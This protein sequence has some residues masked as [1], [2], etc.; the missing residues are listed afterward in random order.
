MYQAETDRLIEQVLDGD[1]E[2]YGALVARYE[3][4]IWKIV[5]V[6]LADSLSAEDMVQEVFIRAYRQLDQY[7][8]GRDFGLWLKAIARNLVR[9]ELR[10]RRRELHRLSRYYAQ[11]EQELLQEDQWHNTQAVLE[12]LLIK[13]I[14]Q[15]P[16]QEAEMVHLRYE[17]GLDFK[18]IAQMKNRSV[19][20]VRQL[21]SRARIR[22]RDLVAQ[23]L[24]R[25]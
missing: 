17:R 4:E 14:A 23:E 9:N 12:E 20:A 13:C 1:L 21:L 3:V 8:M 16:H 24:K 6:L 25:T 18:E 19:P 7:E 5:S 11:I 15:L 10:R 2:A 22:L